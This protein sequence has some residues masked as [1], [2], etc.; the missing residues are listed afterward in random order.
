M[1]PVGAPR[2]SVVMSVFNGERYV[3]EA[4]DSILQQSLTDF[5]LVVVDDGSTD[6]TI[7]ILR[8][9]SDPRLCI[10]RNKENLGLT[11]SL[12][13]GMRVARGALIARQDADDISLP[14][15]LAKQTAF[16]DAH[17]GIGLLGS[18]IHVVDGGGRI[19]RVQRYPTDD[20]SIRWQMLFHNAFC[21]SAVMFRSSSMRNLASFYDESLIYGQDYDAWTRLLRTTSSANLKTPLV[22]WRY[23]AD[24]IQG[25]W[26]AEQQRT[27][28][29]ISMAQ[30][31]ATLG[32]K[33]VHLSSGDC[34]LLRRW[35]LE[36]PCRYGR[37]DVR[38]ATL[39]LRIASAFSKEHA[40]GAV[41]DIERRIFRRAW[42]AVSFRELGVGGVC[43]M[44]KALV[45]ANPRMAL[46]EVMR[47]DAKN[48]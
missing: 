38:A 1:S 32:K 20:V 43:R 2:V 48:G 45:K 47:D 12:N 18:W 44:M 13:K 24:S 40:G 34:D 27:A 39:L 15:R 17:P 33:S 35:Y 22:R 46:V 26:V 41:Q 19:L 14:D 25:R 9:F 31:K 21:H 36:P 8:S 30:I 16:L 23:H 10:L 42:N 4:I 6:N 11:R 28:T 7:R 37:E 3:R 5:E 29:E